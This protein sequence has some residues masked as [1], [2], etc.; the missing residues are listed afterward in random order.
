MGLRVNPDMSLL[1]GYH[2]MLC[3]LLNMNTKVYIY[4]IE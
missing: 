2:D 3:S 1:V 4:M